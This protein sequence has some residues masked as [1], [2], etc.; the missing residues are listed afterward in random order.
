MTLFSKTHAHF[1]T[2]LLIQ[3]TPK[4]KGWFH[5]QPYVTNTLSKLLSTACKYKEY[6][7]EHISTMYILSL[8]CL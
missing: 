7:Y 4:E 2:P 8:K 3:Y 6:N 5:Y 1:K